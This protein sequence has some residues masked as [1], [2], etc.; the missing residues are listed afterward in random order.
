LEDSKEPLAHCVTAWCASLEKDLDRAATEIDI[1]LSLNPNLALAHS[2][3]GTIR[4]YSGQ[5]LEA[6]SRDRAGDGRAQRNRTG[7]LL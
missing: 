4:I 3:R 1:A 5:P 6:R 2:L 7:R